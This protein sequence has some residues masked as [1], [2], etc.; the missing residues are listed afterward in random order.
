M[1]AI[2]HF[3]CSERAFDFVDDFFA[4]WNFLERKCAG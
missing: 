2:P 1:R 3:I 4:R